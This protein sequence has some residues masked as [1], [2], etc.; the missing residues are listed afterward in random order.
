MTNWKETLED[1]GC[2]ESDFC[3]GVNEHTDKLEAFISS[4]LSE[5]A[6]EIAEGVESLRE[7]VPYISTVVITHKERNNKTLDK[8]LSLLEPYISKC[9]YPDCSEVKYHNCP[10]HGLDASQTKTAN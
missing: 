8:V 3:E 1:I 7:K 10:T 6:K 2:C 5:Q 9:P 4:I